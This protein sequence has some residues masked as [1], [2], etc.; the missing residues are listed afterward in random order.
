MANNEHKSYTSYNGPVLGKDH[1][2]VAMQ[3]QAASNVRIPWRGLRS[4]SWSWRWD[5][6]ATGNDESSRVATPQWNRDVCQRVGNGVGQGVETSSELRRSCVRNWGRN[7]RLF[8]SFVLQSVVMLRLT[9]ELGV[10]QILVGLCR[11]NVKFPAPELSWSAVSVELNRDAQVTV[12]SQYDQPVYRRLK[13]S[14]RGQWS[15]RQSRICS[16]LDLY[17]SRQSLVTIHSCM[18]APPCCL[19]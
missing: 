6:M 17:H 3:A 14:V 4:T 13:S 15:M 1:G 11:Y 8:S 5:G 9:N 12:A 18:P 19:E 10:W 2:M 16:V 7:K